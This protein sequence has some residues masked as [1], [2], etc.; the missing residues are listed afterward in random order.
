MTCCE[1]LSRL[2]ESDYID[3]GKVYLQRVGVTTDFPDDLRNYNFCVNCGQELKFHSEYPFGIC[4]AFRNGK[5]NGKIEQR[6]TNNTTT[7]GDQYVF[8]LNTRKEVEQYRPGN[9]N[10]P[11][12][13]SIDYCPY[14][15]AKINEL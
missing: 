12:P 10:Y 14:C 6:K 7:A 9:N 1:S 8:N 4:L 2:R 11:E 5:L 13:I 3:N 15:G